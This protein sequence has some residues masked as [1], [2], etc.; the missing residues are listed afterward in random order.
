MI[1]SH[2]RSNAYYKME[3]KICNY[4]TDDVILL[5]K[6]T[7]L[8]STRLST[9]SATKLN[10]SATKST[11]LATMSTAISCRIQVVADLSPKPAT[12]S[13]VSA[14]KLT[15]LVTRWLCCRSVTSFGNSRLCCQCVPGLRIY[16][17]PA[18]GTRSV[19]GAY[20]MTMMMI[21]FAFRQQDLCSSGQLHI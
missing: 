8:N 16:I 12:K 2:H 17:L 5:H 18:T 11:E 13:T 21:T 9:A 10:V 15:V 3:K 6:A 7:K 14:T 20:K 4:I 19:P 1:H